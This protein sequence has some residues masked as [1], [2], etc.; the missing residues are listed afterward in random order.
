M[1]VFSVTIF[2]SLTFFILAMQYFIVYLN[3]LLNCFQ[4][5]FKACKNREV[6]ISIF[7]MFRI[8]PK[9]IFLATISWSE[10]TFYVEGDGGGERYKREGGRENQRVVGGY[11]S[12]F[13]ICWI[14]RSLCINIY[15]NVGHETRKEECFR[16]GKG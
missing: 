11:H 7:H 14:W 16:K 6:C 15:V 1:N 8:W 4:C 5:Y 3:N 13:C 2:S 12:C 9:V 10:T